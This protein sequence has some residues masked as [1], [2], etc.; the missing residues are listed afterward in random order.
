MEQ[1][2]DALRKELGTKE[3]FAVSAG[4]MISSGLFVLPAVAFGISGPAVIVAYLLASLAVIPAMLSKAELATAM[5][6]SGGVY[7]FI[8]RSFGVLFGL[9]TGFASWFSLSLKSAFALLGIGIF[10]SPLV[11]QLGADTVKI[12]AV[13]FTVL[14]T[15]L[16]LVSVKGTGRLQ[17]LLVMVLLAGLLFFVVTGI[18]RINIDHFSE[19]VPSG[20]FSVL[21]A[22]GLIF[23]SFGGLTK[24]ASVSEEVRDPG[25]SI[26]RGMFGAFAVVSVLYVVI[27]TILVGLLPR[28]VFAETLTPISTA[29]EMVTG[30][31]GFIIL[32]V[33]AMLAFVTTANAGLL[34]ASR[35]PLAM[36][37]DGLIPHAIARVSHKFNTP[38]TAVLLTSAFMIACILFLSLEDLVKVASTMKLLM[39]TFVNFA[40]IFM[41]ESGLVT[42]KPLFK[43]PLYPYLQIAGIVAYLGLI[44]MM[45]ALPL[46]LTA[47]FFVLSGLWYLVYARKA[48]KTESAFFHMVGKLT[49][50]EIVQDESALEGELLSIM[51]ERDEVEEDRFDAIIRKSAVID[52]DRTMGRDEFFGIV[53]EVIAGRWKIPAEQI[54]AK[55]LEREGQASTLIYPGVAVPHAIPHIIIPGE[56]TFDIVLVRNKFG[57]IWNDEGEVVYTAFCLVGTKD[58][59]NFHLKALMSIAQIL[60]DPEF[61]RQWMKART[62]NELRSV[63]LVAERKRE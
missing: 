50:R 34:A 26:P 17:F 13:G 48:G 16:N 3:V 12:I 18:G 14:F 30:R 61:H 10:L 23:I 53:S 58:E 27:V 5:P 52:L 54:A 43:S 6:R 2:Q 49:N 25:K 62:L 11:P 20:W 38:V 31:A 55:L 42:Y 57:I 15:V 19:F 60:Q 9:F 21:A 46:I 37:R 28:A 22:T 39:F 8:A 40:V 44:A 56:H 32:A 41:R 29:A 1:P 24:I 36:A 4:A 33:A 45:G 51:R 7:F 59:R 35:D 63:M 47:A